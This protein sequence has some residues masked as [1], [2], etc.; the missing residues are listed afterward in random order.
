M[1]ARQLIDVLM[2][3]NSTFKILADNNTLPIDD[4]YRVEHLLKRIDKKIL[5]IELTE[6][7]KTGMY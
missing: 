1:K 5:E 2:L 4:K 3:I 7:P 6:I